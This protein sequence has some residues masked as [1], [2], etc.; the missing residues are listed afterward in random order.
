MEHAE[1]KVEIQEWLDRQFEE[2]VRA[3]KPEVVQGDSV[4]LVLEREAPKNIWS[5]SDEFVHDYYLAKD[6]IEISMSTVDILA[7]VDEG[8]EDDIA[9][10]SERPWDASNDEFLQVK[11][12][13]LMTCL[14][15][16]GNAARCQICAGSGQWTF[17]AARWQDFISGEFEG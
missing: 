17:L 11:I 5:L 16:H 14:S 1:R 7:G 10:V 2:W 4:T 15:C 12:E 6:G 13:V 3:Y 9:F 8:A